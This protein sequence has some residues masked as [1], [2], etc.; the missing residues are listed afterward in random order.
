MR[1]LCA[2]DGMHGGMCAKT[3][4]ATTVGDAN[5]GGDLEGGDWVQSNASMVGC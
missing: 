3:K 1:S 2:F 4:R 5:E